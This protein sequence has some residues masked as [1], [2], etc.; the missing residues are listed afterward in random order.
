[1][2]LTPGGDVTF[3]RAGRS[4][5]LGHDTREERRQAVAALEPGSTLLMYTDGVFEAGATSVD[6]SLERLA[7]RVTDAGNV[8]LETLCNYVLPQDTEGREDDAALFACHLAGPD[9]PLLQLQLDADPAQLRVLRQVL[10]RWLS[11]FE[12]GQEDGFQLLLAADEAARNAV[13]HAYGLESGTFLVHA[14][15]ADGAVT[16]RIS[17]AGR[18]RP[19][20][21]RRRGRG[22]S[23]MRKLVDE[24]TIVD[25]DPGTEVRLTRRLHHG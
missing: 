9:E 11:R 12:L 23:L 8:D 24:M 22:I 2:L 15:H 17:D 6:A 19:L 5:L 1:M 21:R 18:W 10:R 7:R 25:L 13:E 20:G 14:E 4:S 3:L 16:I